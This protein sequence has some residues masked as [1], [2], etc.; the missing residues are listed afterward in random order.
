[1]CRLTHLSLRPNLH[2]WVGGVSNH[3]KSSLLQKIRWKFSFISLSSIISW[4]MWQFSFFSLHSFFCVW[5]SMSIHIPFLSCSNTWDWILRL[6]KLYDLALFMWQ[7]IYVHSML[8]MNPLAHKSLFFE[9]S[10]YVEISLILLNFPSCLSMLDHGYTITPFCGFITNTFICLQ[11][12]F[13]RYVRLEA[14]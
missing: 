14:K 11:K 8:R 5:W 3:L 7:L 13:G 9:H 10:L 6:N 1:M 4:F 12:K 2:N